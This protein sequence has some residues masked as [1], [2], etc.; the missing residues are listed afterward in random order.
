M[1]LQSDRAISQAQM[2]CPPSEV[3]YAAAC[4]SDIADFACGLGISKPLQ[5]TYPGL[6]ILELRNSE[7]YRT[8]MVVGRPY[9]RS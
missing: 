1:I 8:R 4:G 5:L 3:T 9:S 2:L 7:K 6:V